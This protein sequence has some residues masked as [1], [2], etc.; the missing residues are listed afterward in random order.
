MYRRVVFLFWGLFLAVFM[1]G[2]VT[3]GGGKIESYKPKSAAESE[4]TKAFVDFQKAYN[5]EDLAGCLSHIHENAQMQTSESGTMVSKKDYSNV[6]EEEWN[7]YGARFQYSIPDITI[8]GDQAV[9]KIRSDWTTK[10]GSSGYNENEMNM[11][12]EGDRWLTMKVT[13]MQVV[14]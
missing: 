12:H 4:M 8:N 1:L 7:N 14:H 13:Y 5:R 11:V 3:G 6:L 2:C 9:V 10:N